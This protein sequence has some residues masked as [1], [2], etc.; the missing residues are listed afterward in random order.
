MKL[1]LGKLAMGLLRNTAPA[2]A[3]GVTSLLPGPA[4][5]AV[6]LITKTF[7]LSKNATP[8]QIESAIENATPDQILA[9]EKEE[10][11]YRLEMKRLDVDV[12]AIVIADKQDARGHYN[13]M[14][15]E[16]DWMIKN[17]MTN[18]Q[19]WVAVMIFVNVFA[20]WLIDYLEMHVTLVAIVSNLIGIFISQMLNER[21][22]AVS[23]RLG[24]SI[25]SKSKDK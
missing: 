4:K 25:G 1:N 19:R 24:S 20:V 6:E 5:K 8:D 15:V 14:K 11:S 22:T 10:N 7:G 2:L 13:D 18:N 9:L 21:Q 17:I 3:A 12:F 16:V 23:Y